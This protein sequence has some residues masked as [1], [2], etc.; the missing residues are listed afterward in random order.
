M[1]ESACRCAPWHHHV[2]SSNKGWVLSCQAAIR[3]QR[4]AS[5]T[6]QATQ[7]LRAPQNRRSNCTLQ[8][9]RGCRALNF[10]NLTDSQLGPVSKAFN[11]AAMCT[12][13]GRRALPARR[14]AQLIGT[15]DPRLQATSWQPAGQKRTTGPRSVPA[16][17]HSIPAL[18]PSPYQPRTELP[19]QW[20]P[21]RRARLPPL[22]RLLRQARPVQQLAMQ[23]LGALRRRPHPLQP[24][25]PGT[26]KNTGLA[27]DA[28]AVAS[29]ATRASSNCCLAYPPAGCCASMH[30]GPGLAT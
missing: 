30:P 10:Y 3:L 4:S 25:P 14:V 20:A 17:R 8:V 22:P 6:S 11:G 1:G 13:S 19:A 27:C 5:T 26:T 24:A 15:T 29:G 9:M 12:A 7:L 18:P 23:P 21:L 2:T 16:P 28:T